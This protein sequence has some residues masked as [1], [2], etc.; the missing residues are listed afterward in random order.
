MMKIKEISLFFTTFI[1]A[2]LL[3]YFI[4]W[5]NNEDENYNL[6]SKEMQNF[7]DINYV[8]DT[9][10]YVKDEKIENKNIE[11]ISVKNTPEKNIEQIENIKKS[12]NKK[13]IE[14]SFDPEDLAYNVVWWNKINYVYNILDSNKFENLDINTALTIKNENWKIRWNFHKN[15]INMF[16][17]SLKEK[18]F[19]RVF[20]HE[21][22]HYVDIEFLNKNLLWNDLSNDFYNISWD[23]TKTIKKWQSISSFVSWYSMTNK[24]EDFAESFT[25]YI[26][27]NRDF[28]NKS[29][30]NSKLKL[31]YDYFTKYIFKNNYFINTSFSKEK[32]KDYYW[33]TTKVN[34]NL[35]S[36]IKY[37][38]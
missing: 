1:F 23:N 11:I 5:L 9:N 37:I 22:W 10:S 2:F 28:K 20:I 35:D 14:I 21:L 19:L 17:Y 4:W 33:D 30:Y 13:Y 31:K 32:Y 7:T 18:E 36:F 29:K 8:H 34:Y 27:H 12:E 24:Y 3:S 38:Q 6:Y 16:K 15:N 25:Y 26:L